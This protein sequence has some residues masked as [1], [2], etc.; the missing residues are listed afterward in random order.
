M[1]KFE[2]V[3]SIKVTYEAHEADDFEADSIEDAARIAY[4]KARAKVDQEFNNVNIGIDDEDL[5]TDVR[6]LHDDGKG[7]FVEI[8]PTEKALV[9]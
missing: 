4:D 8:I 5:F 7:E 6:I 2:L 3:V 9:A 1:K